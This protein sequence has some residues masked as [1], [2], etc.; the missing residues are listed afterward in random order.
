MRVWA[1][2]YRQLASTGDTST[3]S[4]PPK[5]NNDRQTNR[6]TCTTQPT[7]TCNL[8]LNV[9]AIFVTLEQTFQSPRSRPASSSPSGVPR[10]HHYPLLSQ[11]LQG[12]LA[13]LILR[14]REQPNNLQTLGRM[15][16]CQTQ[17]HGTRDNS[18]S[19]KMRRIDR[20]DLTTSVRAFSRH[21]ELR[22]MPQYRSIG[23]PITASNIAYPDA[24]GFSGG[25]TTSVC[26]CSISHLKKVAVLW[27]DGPRT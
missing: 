1:D 13:A 9:N 3:H 16:M 14:P 21:L 26:A 23:N 22:Q 10:S 2:R 24:M 5:F 4:S 25:R 27:R 12:F 19:H 20:S 15:S 18:D 17:R 6:R 8:V 7:L 11:K